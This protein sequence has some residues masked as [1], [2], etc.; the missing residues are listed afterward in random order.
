MDVPGFDFRAGDLLVA[1]TA[2]ALGRTIQRYQRRRFGATLGAQVNHVAVVR[3]GDDADYSGWVVEAYWPWVRVVMFEEW[4]SAWVNEDRGEWVICLRP[5]GLNVAERAH[6]SAT[7]VGFKGQPYDARTLLR[8]GRIYRWWHP[9]RWWAELLVA[10]YRDDAGSLTC[11]ELA[12]RASAVVMDLPW[13]NLD[14]VC[15]AEIVD[16]GLW[17]RVWWSS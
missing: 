3:Y 13:T 17:H 15:P 6:I 11:S 12:A 5:P 7:A 2:G 9:C 8:L 10:R 14:L 16:S 4:F 1:H